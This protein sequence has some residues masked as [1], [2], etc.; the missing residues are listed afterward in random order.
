MLSIGSK[1]CSRPT[2]PW[3]S[4]RST[5]ETDPSNV[6]SVNCWSHRPRNLTLLSTLICRLLIACVPSQSLHNFCPTPVTRLLRWMFLPQQM[7][8]KWC[9]LMTDYS[10]MDRLQQAFDEA[11]VGA[12]TYFDLNS[13]LLTD[14][15]AVRQEAE[16]AVAASRTQI[17]AL[18]EDKGY[19]RSSLADLNATHNSL[20]AHSLSQTENIADLRGRLPDK[21]PPLLLFPRPLLLTL[22]TDFSDE[23]TPDDSLYH[24]L[25]ADPAV[26]R[27]TLASN[28]KTLL[29]FLHPDKSPNPPVQCVVWDRQGAVCWIPLPLFVCRECPQLDCRVSGSFPLCDACSVF[30]SRAC[31]ILMLISGTSS[32]AAAV[33]TLPG[34][35]FQRRRHLTALSGLHL[36]Q[37]SAK[38]RHNTLQR[39][40]RLVLH[41]RCRTK[42]KCSRTEAIIWHDVTNNSLTPHSSNFN[43]PLS[44][45][46]LIHELC[47]LPCDIAAIVYCQ[48]TGSPDVYHLL[49]QSFVVISPVRHLLSHLQQRPL[50]LVRQYSVVHLAIHLELQIPFFCCPN[51]F[52][53]W[54]VWIRRN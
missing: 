11:R 9:S 32:L 53:T 51:T 2:A 39:Q 40:L 23:D 21:Q 29:C 35:V 38:F 52:I 43:R 4:K 25:W 34:G 5:P 31:Y 14:L 13:Q 24:F 22:P 30:S 6:L 42:T 19:L 1:N 49:R 18:Q 33:N 48:R 16:E 3:F 50:A 7:I 20:M 47:S 45:P 28:A 46:D 54:R 17:Q 36:I 8:V 37:S 10:S 27:T 26:D 44:P 15:A 12:Q 41:F